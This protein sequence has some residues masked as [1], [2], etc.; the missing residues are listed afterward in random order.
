MGILV[1]LDVGWSERRRSC[2]VAVRGGTLSGGEQVA[3]GDVSSVALNRRDV[4]AALQRTVQEALARGQRVL[5]VAD[6]I[7]GRARVPICDRRI[8]E[9]CSIQGFYRRAQSCP[10]T[11]D[12]GI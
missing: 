3:Y 1:G 11:Q 5:V 8:D 2:G 4:P 9:Q 6:A 10:A 12:T 7:V